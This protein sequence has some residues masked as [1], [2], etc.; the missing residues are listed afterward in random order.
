MIELIKKFVR[1]EAERFG[2]KEDYIFRNNTGV[3]ALDDNGAYFGFIHPGEENSGP[4]HDFSFVIFPTNNSEAWLAC[5]GI[6][7]SGFKNDYDLA[8]YPGPRRFFSKLIDDD[9]YCK[10]DFSDIETSL[11]K[12]FLKRDDLVHL[13]RTIEKYKTVLLVAQIIREPNSEEG[14]MRISALLAGYAKLRAWASNAAQRNSISNA[15]DAVIKKTK[16]DHLSDVTKLLLERKYVVL[17]GAPGTGK[18]R[19]AKLVANEL[20]ART[21]FTQFHAETSYSDFIYGIRPKLNST[22]V[23]YEARNGELLKSIKYAQEYQNEKVV[24]IIDELNR[25]NLANVLGPIFYLF[26]HKQQS[27]NVTIELSPDQELNCMPANLYVLGTMNTA[28]RSLAVVDFALRRRF[29]WYDLRP[30]SIQNGCEGNVFFKDHFSKFAE[31]FD[32]YANSNELTLQP[33]QGYFIARDLNE[34]RN[35]IRYELLP[36]IREYLQEGLLNN[37]REEFNNYFVA[38]IGQ[39]LFE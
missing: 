21:F 23:S 3:D 5:L 33:G 29:A 39:T 14:K 17:Q 27:S 12:N 4:Y 7:S 25:A 31:I 13:K 16:C 20:K 1:E 37:A 2:A 35:R 32:W 24:L 10:S 36:L 9:G 8:R 28:D 19:L 30:E 22:D 15:I 38:E 18:T 6:G 26:E 11:P 34:M